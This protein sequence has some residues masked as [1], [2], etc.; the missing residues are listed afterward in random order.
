M[1]QIYQKAFELVKTYSL[2][3]ATHQPDHI[4]R[5]IELT[6]YLAKEEGVINQIDLES[7]KLAAIFHDL[8]SLHRIKKLR[9]SED[10][11]K[12]EEHAEKGFKIAQKFLKQEGFSKEQIKKIQIIITS[13]GAN[14]SAGD[15][16][17]HLLHDADL[18]DGIGLGGVLRIF[19]FGGQINRS[20]IG[21]LE[22]TKQKVA[23]RQFKTKSGQKL[24][25]E[26]IKK[27][28]LWLKEVE[29]ELEGKD[30]S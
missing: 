13:H 20:V 10:K 12:S 23:S 4:E 18:L 3:D 2:T 16:E 21:S 28:L 30:L 26:R 22:Y 1:D 24:G 5:V 19:T 6:E 8:G 7:L 15:L 17:G 27:V 25:K 14:G 9:K 11:F 29:K